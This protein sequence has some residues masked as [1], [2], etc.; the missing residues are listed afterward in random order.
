MATETMVAQLRTLKVLKIT[1]DGTCIFSAVFY[2]FHL[3]NP[4]FSPDSSSQTSYTR[5][6]MLSILS[7]KMLVIVTF[8]LNS[9]FLGKDF[10]L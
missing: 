5:W 8:S 3:R 9:A 10:L 7:M 2:S 4:L 6:P 1:E